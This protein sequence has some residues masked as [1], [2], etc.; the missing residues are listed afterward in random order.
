M[1]NVNLDFMYGL[2]NQTLDVW[3]PV[4]ILLAGLA[5]FWRPSPDG[6][7][8]SICLAGAL[9]LPVIF[10]TA[11]GVETQGVGLVYLVGCA[12]AL[13][14]LIEWALSR[15]LGAIPPGRSRRRPADGVLSAQ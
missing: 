15:A 4:L 13:G 1:E 12:L 5:A 7:L 11:S 14:S 9:A 6:A 2:P 10:T 3:P 8:L